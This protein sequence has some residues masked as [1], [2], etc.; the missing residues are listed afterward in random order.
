MALKDK[1]THVTYHKGVD[2]I[3]GTNI[4][5]AYGDA[6]IFFDLGTE[7]RPELDLPDESYQTL[8][9]NHLIP[10]LDDFYD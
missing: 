2:T 4:E 8:I 6:H 3:G 9:Q 7:Y 5:I 10:K 1:Q